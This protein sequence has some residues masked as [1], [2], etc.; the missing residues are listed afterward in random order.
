MLKWPS[1]EKCGVSKADDG[2]DGTLRPQPLA[3]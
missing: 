2:H 1:V 3:L